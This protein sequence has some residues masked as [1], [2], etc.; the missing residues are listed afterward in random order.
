MGR[1]LLAICPSLNRYLLVII[2][3]VTIGEL[4][5]IV[6]IYATF[7]EPQREIVIVQALRNEFWISSCDIVSNNDQKL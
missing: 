4:A 3:A 6:S 7:L 2:N 5:H 1:Y